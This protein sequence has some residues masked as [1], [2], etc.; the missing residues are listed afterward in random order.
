MHDD[1]EFEFVLNERDATFEAVAALLLAVMVLVSAVVLALSKDDERVPA[2]RP[3]VTQPGPDI[4]GT[5]TTVTR[6]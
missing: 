2:V 4:D 3:S 5:L 1:D 6:P